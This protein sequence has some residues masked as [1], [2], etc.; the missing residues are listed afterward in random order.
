MQFHARGIW[1]RWHRNVA[2]LLL[3][4][5]VR[6]FKECLDVIKKDN[7]RNQDLSVV[8]SRWWQMCSVFAQLVHARSK[9]L[10]P[11]AKLSS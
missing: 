7:R 5:W 11:A 3:H 8:L 2:K 10:L 9:V 4:C 6:V 1:C